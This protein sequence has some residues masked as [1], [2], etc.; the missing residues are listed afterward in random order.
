ML[1]T[2]SEI[3]QQA[4]DI[5]HDAHLHSG[6]EFEKIFYDFIR[7]TRIADLEEVERMVEEITSKTTKYPLMAKE[8]NGNVVELPNYNYGYHK[9]LD[10]VLFLTQKL[11]E[12]IGK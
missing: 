10:L 5:A 9:A 11:K 12:E 1:K 8:F 6:F 2:T 3:A 7:Q 4:I